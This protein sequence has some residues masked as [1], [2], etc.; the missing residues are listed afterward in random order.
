MENFVAPSSIYTFLKYCNSSTLEKEILDC[1]AGGY[2]PPLFIFSNY[3]YKTFGIEICKDQIEKSN[4]FCEKNK[5]NL[6]IVKGDMKILPFEDNRFS[7]VYT[8]NTTVH[9]QKKDFEI[10]IKEVERVTKS[11]GLFFVNF[12]S[13]ECSTYGKG[14][15]VNRGEFIQSDEE[16]DVLFC[17]YEDSEAENYF[18]N[19]DIIHKEKKIVE[20]LIDGEK[21]ISGFIEYILKKK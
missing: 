18:L 11:R 2:N 15:E 5:I 12:L 21:Y 3:G 16:G 19:F 17:H 14:K 7:F 8:Y 1:G 20:R 9:M 6:N 4:S 13:F 10:V